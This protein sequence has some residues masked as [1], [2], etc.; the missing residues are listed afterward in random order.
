MGVGT[1]YMLFDLRE[2]V[3]DILVVFSLT[4]DSQSLLSF[5]HKSTCCKGECSKTYYITL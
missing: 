5:F 2:W 4:S 1:M 3:V